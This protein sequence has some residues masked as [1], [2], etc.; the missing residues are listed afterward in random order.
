[1]H[2]NV[3][4]ECTFFVVEDPCPDVVRLLGGYLIIPPG[5]FLS[6][7]ANAALVEDVESGF[8]IYY[9]YFIITPCKPLGV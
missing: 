7:V 9:T 1:M 4:N 3:E 2:L 5:F 8:W 6:H